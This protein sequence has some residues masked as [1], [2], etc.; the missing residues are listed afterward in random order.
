MTV[1]DTQNIRN[2][3]A[4]TK[5]PRMVSVFKTAVFKIH[6]PSKHKRAMLHDAMKRAHICFGK[7]LERNLPDKEEVQSLLGGTAQQDRDNR[8]FHDGCP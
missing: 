5:S 8:S 6:N 2:P 7:L 1:P 4:E 3:S